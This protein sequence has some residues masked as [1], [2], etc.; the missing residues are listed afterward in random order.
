M[1]IIIIVGRDE[2]TL[3]EKGFVC[4]DPFTALRNKYIPY[5][6]K[7]IVNYSSLEGY[8]LKNRTFYLY[9]KGANFPGVG[10]TKITWSFKSDN[11]QKII[12]ILK[13]KSVKELKA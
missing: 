8:L 2:I 4:A 11:P 10:Y 7:F 9:S 5:Y 12:Q 13:S 6:R 1:G 3:M